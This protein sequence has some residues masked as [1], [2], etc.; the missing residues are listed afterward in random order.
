[1][2]ADPAQLESALLN[3]ALNARDAM[4]RS[5][6]VPAGRI[7]IEVA[8]AALD[9]TFAGTHDEVAP[10][11]YVMFAV[12]DNGSGMSPEQ[13]ARA[14]EPFYTT[15]PD[16]KGTGLGLPMVFGFAKQSGGHFQLYS[17]PGHG[18]TARLY[19][20]RTRAAVE[21]RRRS[22]SR[23]YGAA[24]GELVLLVEDDSSVRRVAADALH[25]LGYTVHEAG[26]GDEALALLEAGIRPA[27]LFTDV[28]MPGTTT[29]RE[30]AIR[31]QAM[32]PGLAVLFTSGYTAE[33]VMQNGA[34]PAG[35]QPDQQALAHRGS[36]PCAARRAGRGPAAR[37]DDLVAAWSCWWRTRRWFG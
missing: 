3:L 36:R 14:M 31:A 8:N 32:V 28:V 34:D 24:N 17:E 12:T 23:S 25:K 5:D 22:A 2:R 35:R 16:G 26:N 19:I 29:S 7:T 27:V 33:F 37:G 13:L 1:M 18:T 6:G 30:L 9:E 15:K 10:G 21:T 4:I 20:P 11:E